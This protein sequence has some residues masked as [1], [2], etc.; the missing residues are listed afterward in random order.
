ME[1]CIL[2]WIDRK[3]TDRRQWKTLMEEGGGGEGGGERRRQLRQ[4][5]HNERS[6]SGGGVREKGLGEGGRGGT[7]EGARGKVGGGGGGG[8]DKCAQW[9]HG[10]RSQIC[11]AHLPTAK[12]QQSLVSTASL[13]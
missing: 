10:S 5:R 12:P 1:G 11:F 2:Q 6:R 7:E 3:A 4:G 8:R 13:A 9:Q